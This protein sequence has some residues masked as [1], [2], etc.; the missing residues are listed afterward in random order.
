MKYWEILEY[1]MSLGTRE[2][3]I[4][5]ILIIH[6]TLLRKIKSD[7]KIETHAVKNVRKGEHLLIAGLKC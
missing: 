1:V 4:K 2:I 6:F 7:L 3:Q 5:T